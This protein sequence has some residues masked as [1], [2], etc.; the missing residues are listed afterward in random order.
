MFFK[1]VKTEQVPMTSWTLLPDLFDKV[2]PRLLPPLE[3][4]GR[5]IIPS[6]V[7]ADLWCGN[8]SIVNEETEEG[9]GFDPAAF[10]AHNE[11]ELGNWRPARNQFTRLYFNEYHSHVP[12]AEPAEDYDDRNALYSL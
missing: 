9:I 11:Y 12:K 8:A 4:S 6:L 1:S 7:H 3:T 2:I 10:W 5:T